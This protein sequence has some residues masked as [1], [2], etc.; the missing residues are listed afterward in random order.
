ML[1]SVAAEG[2][3][4]PHND[5]SYVIEVEGGSLEDVAVREG[6]GYLQVVRLQGNNPI[7]VYANCE[8]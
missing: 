8:D 1:A 2:P 7:S 6:N 5:S 3:R 4:I